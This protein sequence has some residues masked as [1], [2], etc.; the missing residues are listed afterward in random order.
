M[1]RM[2]RCGVKI[3]QSESLSL[4]ATYTGENKI[5]EMQLGVNNNEDIY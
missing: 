2:K 4:T 5:D 3:T 1:G